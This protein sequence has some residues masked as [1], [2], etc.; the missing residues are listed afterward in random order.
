MRPSFLQI[1]QPVQGSYAKYQGS[2]D[3]LQKRVSLY[4]DYIN[5][6]YFHPPNGGSRNAVEAAKLKKM[7]VKAGVPDLII[8]DRHHGFHGLALE[9]K[10]GTN[11]LTANQIKWLERLHGLGWCCYVSWSLDEILVLIDWYYGICKKN[12]WLQ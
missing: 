7:G 5:A 11:N 12:L 1:P 6:I 2:E 10:V 9:L 8:L 3:D 4:L